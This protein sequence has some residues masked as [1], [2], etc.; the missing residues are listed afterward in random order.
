MQIY[1]HK[2]LF[3]SL[4]L[5]VFLFLLFGCDKN[6]S[7]NNSLYPEAEAQNIDSDLLTVAYLTA[8]Q[9]QGIKSLLVNRNDVLVSEEYFGDG[10]LDSLNHVRS[11]TK[12]V[13]SALIGIAIDKGFVQDVNRT[14]TELLSSVVDSL[15]E[16][17]GQITI[18]HLLTMTSGFQWD[19]MNNV[20][21]YNNWVLSDDQIKYILNRP[22]VDTP[23]QRFN[24]NTA[25]SHLLSV[26]LTEATGMSTLDFAKQYLFT[27]LGIESVAWGRF[28]QGYYNGGADLQLRPQDMIKL[29][30]LYL[31][32][33]IYN[34]SQIIPSEW[35]ANTTQVQI[36]TNN[37]VPFGPNYGYLW[38]MGRENNHDLYF[39]NGYGGQFIVN[40]PDLNLVVVATSEWRSLG[41]RAGEQWYNVLNLIMSM[42]LPAVR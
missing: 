22:L 4:A 11:V 8:R 28:E 37:A 36:S 29:G 20:T 10:G 18:Q 38:W 35:I 26:I 5:P 17:K 12:S 1:I 32:Q 40:V 3:L 23:G 27:P 42:V 15:D 2:K 41:G 9:T 34:S 14:L 24:Y 21:E 30:R 6:P 7:G 16:A 31:E 19:E 25:A 39:A 33:G 13:M